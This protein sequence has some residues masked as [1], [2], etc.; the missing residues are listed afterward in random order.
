MSGITILGQYK[1]LTL[2]ED[3][4]SKN[5][6]FFR[7]DDK[8]ADHEEELSIQDN[9]V[10]WTAGQIVKRKITLE[11]RVIQVIWANFSADPNKNTKTDLCIL[12][13]GTNY[14][15]IYMQM[16]FNNNSEGLYVL[17]DQ[18]GSSYWNVHVSLPCKMT[19]LW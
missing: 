4:A 6:F 13:Q 11:H 8:L 18:G 7:P 10:I 14:S 1:P 15:A 9:V 19:A 5:Y 3:T 16:L 17:V 12:H 2:R